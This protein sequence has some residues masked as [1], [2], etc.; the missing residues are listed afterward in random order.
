MMCVADVRNHGPKASPEGDR[1]PLAG[2]CPIHHPFRSPCYRMKVNDSIPRTFKAQMQHAPAH[3]EID[4]GSLQRRRSVRFGVLSSDCP[5]CCAAPPRP[6][7]HALV[8]RN[9]QAPPPRSCTT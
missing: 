8:S 6:T 9:A 5:A 7:S 2:L 3:E 1:K 4:L